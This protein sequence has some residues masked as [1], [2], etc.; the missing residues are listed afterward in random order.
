MLN[1][2]KSLTNYVLKQL[3]QVFIVTITFSLLS[4]FSLSN[5]SNFSDGRV[6]TETIYAT[7]TIPTFHNQEQE[8]VI[9][10]LFDWVD[11]YQ[12]L[13]AVLWSS[14][15]LALLVWQ[16]LGLPR[17]WLDYTS[18]TLLNLAYFFIFFSPVSISTSKSDVVYLNRGK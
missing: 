5:S 10:P 17:P 15:Y 16:T 1:S 11:T 7:L 2:L 12:Y 18:N 6:L 8:E 3:F 13:N 4:N 14:E 9:I